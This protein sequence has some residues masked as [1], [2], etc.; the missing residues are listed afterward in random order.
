MKLPTLTTLV[1]FAEYTAKFLA[2][3]ST[4]SALSTSLSFLYRHLFQQAPIFRAC[5]FTLIVLA[6]VFLPEPSYC[7]PKQKRKGLSRSR[8]IDNFLFDPGLF[9]T[10]ESTGT[11]IE[12]RSD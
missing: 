8:S 3:F 1:S 12:G 4:I 6:E 10:V 11:G 9:L 5:L 7:P 2:F